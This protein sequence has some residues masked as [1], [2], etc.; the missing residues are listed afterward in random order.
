V[1]QSDRRQGNT[2]QK[3]YRHCCEVAKTGTQ[4]IHNVESNVVSSFRA[5]REILCYSKK[6]SLVVK[7]ILFEMTQELIPLQYIKGSFMFDRIIQW[8]LNN[9]LLDIAVYIVSITGGILMIRKDDGGSVPWIPS[10]QV[11]I[12]IKSTVNEIPNVEAVRSKSSVGRSTVVVVFRWGTTST[13]P[14]SWSTSGF[15]SPKEISHLGQ[16]TVILP[17]TSAVSWLI[18]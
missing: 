18:K 13:R 1:E 16:K 10:P 17:V 9:R 7:K 2:H 6:R 4:L 14:D 8:S 11:V 12:S 15:N 5:Q 3:T